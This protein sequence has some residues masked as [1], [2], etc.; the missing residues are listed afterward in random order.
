MSTPFVQLAQLG[1]KLEQTSKRSELAALLAD[2]LNQLSPEEIPPAVRLVIGQIFPEWDGRTLNVSWKAVMAVVNELVDAPPSLREEV[3]AQAVD[4]GQAVRLLL[5][6]ARRQPPTSPPLTILEVFHHFEEIAATLGQGSRARKEALLR[7]LLERAT[8]LEAK[9]LVKV[10]SGEM[11]HGVSEGI[12]LEGIARAAAVKGRLVRRANQLWS[13]LGEVALV[14]LTQGEP[15]LKKATLRLFRPIKPM[16]AQTADD[17]SEVFARY[18]TRVALEY[19]LDG[20]RVQIHRRGDEVRIYSRHLADVT[21]SLPDVVAEIRDKLLVSEA[22]LEGEV[23]AV[24]KQGRPLPFQHLMRRFRRRHEV[25]ATI[26]EIPVQLHLFDVLYTEGKPLVDMPNEERWGILQ[27]VA[28]ELN[29]VRRLIPPNKAEGEAFAADAYRHG[30]EGVMAKALGSAYTPGVRGKSWLKL[31]HVISLDLV[32]VAADWGYGRRHGWL[33]NYH[34]AARDA[35]SGEYLVV[36]KTF[37]GLTDAEFQTM[38]ERLLNLEQ[39][40]KGS[41][42]FVRPEVV[43]EVLFNEIQKS[44]QYRSGLALRFA[45]ISRL[46]EDKGPHEADTIQTLRQLYEKQFRYKGR[47]RAEE[48]V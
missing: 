7:G 29:L 44:S 4:G 1:E 40:R 11:R 30:H 10:I 25:A 9:Y 18:G 26:A 39:R 8:P 17:L 27:K 13:D 41:T 22:I 24:D 35:E 45:R 19:K 16:L 32:I 43:V 46:R 28:G 15:G 37:K 48:Q 47:R 14:A 42:V 33:S 6:R 38:T 2:F 34:L 5:E 23:V 21:A 3:F 12:M 31:K 20:A 36:G